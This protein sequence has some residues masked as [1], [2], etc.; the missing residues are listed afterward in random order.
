VYTLI[1]QFILG[2]YTI[3]IIFNKSVDITV[4]KSIYWRKHKRIQQKCTLA[5]KTI[6]MKTF[7]TL[8][9]RNG[10]SSKIYYFY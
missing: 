9:K 4:F 2:V 3:I 7:I 8:K 10:I 6:D 5:F 1:H